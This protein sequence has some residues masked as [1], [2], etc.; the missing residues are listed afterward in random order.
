MSAISSIL[1]AGSLNTPSTA[2][3]ANAKSPQTI[4]FLKLLMAQMKNQN[5]MEPQNGTE[6]MTQIAQ[7]SQ[8]DATNQLNSSF[9]NLIALQGLTQ[10]ASLIGKTVSYATT[11]GSTAKGAVT[12]VASNGGKIQLM[13][14]GAGIDLSQVRTVEAGPKTT[15]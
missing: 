2:G 6:F 15:N 11:N 4:D 12:S 13:I 5:P 8:L 1:S 9:N 3:A 14:G 7:F 10:S